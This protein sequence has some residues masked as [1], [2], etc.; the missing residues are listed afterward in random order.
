MDALQGLTYT[1]VS[2]AAL[3]Y[4]NE[5]RMKMVALTMHRRMKKIF[6]HHEKE[7]KKHFDEAGTSVELWWSE[8]GKAQALQ[9]LTE[10]MEEETDP[11]G[12]MMHSIF[13]QGQLQATRNNAHALAAHLLSI[14]TNERFYE[15]LSKVKADGAA[16]QIA[17]LREKLAQHE[18]E[19]RNALLEAGIDLEAFEAY[20]AP[21]TPTS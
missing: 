14:K 20:F 11:I 7:L 4:I 19:H 18:D 3:L 5:Q 15:E 12:E 21:S 13:A 17:E 1:L 6:A 2:I 16:E 9:R 8:T 10:E